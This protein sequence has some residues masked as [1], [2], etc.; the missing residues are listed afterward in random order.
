MNGNGSTRV[1]GMPQ[2][3]LLLAASSMSVLGA[4]LIAPVLPLMAK[5]FGAT[6]GVA[7]LVPIV[8]TVPAL[9][10]GLASPFAGVVVDRLGRVRLLVAAM[11]AYAIFGTAPLYLDG[12]GAI[13]GSRVMV[14]V[15]EAAIMTCCTTLIGD[16]WSGARRNRYLGLQATV[17]A[18]SAT[19]FVLLG[20][21]LG[22]NGWRTPFWMYLVS[23]VLVIPM[24]R[25]LWAPTPSPA[26]RALRS[27]VPWRKLL[28][29]CCVTFLGGIVFYALIVQLSYVLDAA[30]V[31][32]T[33]LIGLI[34][35]VMAIATATGG[36]AF[37]R[38]A[39]LGR[40]KLLIGEFLLSAV[41]LV[42]VAASDAVPVITVGA[43]LTGLG[44]G[45]LLP[46]LLTWALDQLDFAH[47]GRGTGLWTGTLFVGQFLSPLVIASV[48]SAAGGLRPA[49]TVLGVASAV[50]AA[51]LWFRM[52]SSG[53][54]AT[55]P[56]Q[57]LA[58]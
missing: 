35:A 32:S 44:T 33:G 38:L 5:E 19:L 12:L 48:A 49:L 11:V 40:K 23:L 7:V 41:G 15:C 39:V 30:G 27:P 20:G 13:I 9:M 54:V 46:T 51:A 6:P 34:S 8:L 1:A 4:V 14:G 55:L 29:P 52:T 36:A 56:D 21:L 47:R 2:L 17:A 45:A 16:Y 22:A 42:V 31:T 28:A 53:Q 43:V 18:I 24:A 58:P 10:I 25:S 57:A 50:M 26:E 37:G 3:I